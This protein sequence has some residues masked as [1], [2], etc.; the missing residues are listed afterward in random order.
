[1]FTKTDACEN[2]TLT[3]H[4]QQLLWSKI[5]LLRLVQQSK[6]VEKIA[7]ASPCR[8]RPPF[9]CKLLLFL[10]EQRMKSE[11]GS[12]PLVKRPRLKGALRAHSASP[13]SRWKMSREDNRSLLL[14][15]IT[16]TPD[17]VILHRSSGQQECLFFSPHEERSGR[18][19]SERRCGCGRRARKKA[20]GYNGTAECPAVD[21]R[22]GAEGRTHAAPQ[23]RFPTQQELTFTDFWSDSH[24]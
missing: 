9:A 19:G 23:Q 7:S 3:F 15:G 11:P 24:V 6:R 20:T 13:T 14:E 5:E 4:H 21:S 16:W 1:M 10:G 18:R 22:G 12:P 8:D 2:T 17:R